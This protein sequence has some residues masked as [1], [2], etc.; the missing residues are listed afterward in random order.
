MLERAAEQAG[1]VSLVHADGAELPFAE[2][3]LDAAI[4][5]HVI[6]HTPRE[7]STALLGEAARVLRP[8]GA[9]LVLDHAWHRLPTAGWR[10]SMS[11]HLAAGT[12]S[13]R[14]LEAPAEA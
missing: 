8:G 7:A 6:G 13:L 11:Q 2:R 14:V 5:I 4:A 10:E 3:S 12:L 9:L 1:L